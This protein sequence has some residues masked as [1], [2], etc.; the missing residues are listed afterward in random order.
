MKITTKTGYKA[1]LERYEKFAE[2]E[3]KLKEK[4][5]PLKDAIRDY[6]S[7]KGPQTA[8]GWSA[9]ILTSQS[10]RFKPQGWKRFLKDLAETKKADKIEQELMTLAIAKL[11]PT[12]V[13]QVVR[14]H[15]VTGIHAVRYMDADSVTERFSLKP[16]QKEKV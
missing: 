9:A 6:V 13:D 8:F 16:T 11:T 3:A 2:R 10:L 12:E 14:R 4:L 1:A 5:G 15:K 7:R